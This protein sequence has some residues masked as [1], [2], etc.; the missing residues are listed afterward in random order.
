MA[1]GLV[2]VNGRVE[3]RRGHKLAVGDVVEALGVMVEMTARC[4]GP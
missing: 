1:E 2:L 3:T 4:D